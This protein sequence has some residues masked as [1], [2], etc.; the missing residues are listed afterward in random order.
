MTKPALEKFIK[1]LETFNEKTIKKD[2]Y[3]ETREVTGD[4]IIGEYTLVKGQPIH[5]LLLR[6]DI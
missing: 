1:R 5:V 3:S 2:D 4:N 6:S